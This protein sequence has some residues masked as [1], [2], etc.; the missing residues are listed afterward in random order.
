MI[1]LGMIALFCVLCSVMWA[2]AL[3]QLH[4]HPLALGLATCHVVGPTPHMDAPCLLICTHDF[5]HIDLLTVIRES[6]AWRRRT[7][8]IV[9]DRWFNRV[10]PL[11]GVATI[12]TG[13][14]T[15]E[16]A[17]R[18]LAT[19]HV[20]IFLYRDTR[21]TGAYRIM[22][23]HRGPV[24]HVQV[25]RVRPE[26]GELC[27]FS[28]RQCVAVTAGHLFSCRYHDVT[29]SA[30]AMVLH[31]APADAMSAIVHELYRES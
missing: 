9:A 8:L 5:Q 28:P 21:N 4:A 19:H 16:R 15:V 10:W 23:A 25:R 14:G 24:M 29:E 22:Q 26:G 11:L 2:F 18:A 13:G 27:G 31:K 30:R 17:V 7:A 1:G 12:R 20:C 3:A 6:R